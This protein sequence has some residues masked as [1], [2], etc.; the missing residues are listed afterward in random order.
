MTT[1]SIVTSRVAET[2]RANEKTSEIDA[3]PLVFRWKCFNRLD[4]HFF[5]KTKVPCRFS[6][7]TA[8]FRA[9]LHALIYV[10]LVIIFDTQYKESSAFSDSPAMDMEPPTY[11]E[12]YKG[13]LSSVAMYSLELHPGDKTSQ[14]VP[15]RS[16]C[17][18]FRFLGVA[19]R[20]WR[21][22]AT[23]HQHH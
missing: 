8:G 22:V 18:S 1:I 23:T 7:C 13:K 2:R 21:R 12:L 6:C 5:T 9:Y 19:L 3:D 11:C 16:F 15:A 4:L 10:Y 20:L 17:Y 14:N